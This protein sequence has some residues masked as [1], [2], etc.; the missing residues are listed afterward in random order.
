[1]VCQLTHISL[2]RFPNGTSCGF[3]FFDSPIFN[4]WIFHGVF[5]IFWWKD[6]ISATYSGIGGIHTTNLPQR[7][8]GQWKGILRFIVDD[9][10]SPYNDNMMITTCVPITEMISGNLISVR[11]LIAFFKF[12]KRS[13]WSKLVVLNLNFLQRIQRLFWIESHLLPSFFC[14]AFGTADSPKFFESG[15]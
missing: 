6:S 13:I 14:T 5:N 11:I 15:L 7:I 4:R 9:H 1:M 8:I 10:T 12:L 3:I 2:K